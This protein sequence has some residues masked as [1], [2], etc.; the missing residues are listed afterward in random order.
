MG[1]A[2]VT[3]S[4]WST[5]PT[6]PASRWE[7]ARAGAVSPHLSSHLQLRG[8]QPFSGKGP[9]ANILGFA[10]L[11]CDRSSTRHSRPTG[12]HGRHANKQTRPC[13]DAVCKNRCRARVR[14]SLQQAALYLASNV[15][16]CVSFNT[17]LVFA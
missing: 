1:S 7:A 5:L 12:S 15:F 11:C 10:G 16:F 3:D 4:T 8:G 9:T 17:G 2:M 6:R 13:P 14:W